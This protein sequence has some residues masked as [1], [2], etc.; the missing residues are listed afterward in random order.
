MFQNKLW[1]HS[2]QDNK[3]ETLVAVDILKVEVI[4]SKLDHQLLELVCHH[5]EE[6]VNK[7]Q[8]EVRK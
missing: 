7:V 8:E 3:E 1:V 6:C 4:K 5:Q 2:Q